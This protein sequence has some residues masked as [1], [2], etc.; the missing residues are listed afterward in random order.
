MIWV[1]LGQC[2]QERQVITHNAKLDLLWL[3]HKCGLKIDNVFCTFTASHLLTNGKQELR[4][5][6]Y[7]CLERFLGLSPAMTKASPTGVGCF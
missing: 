1:N 6:L 4:N 5:D 3:R 7:P 2:L